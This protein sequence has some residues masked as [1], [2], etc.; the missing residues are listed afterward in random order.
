MIVPSKLGPGN[1]VCNWLFMFLRG[2]SHTERIG[3]TY[4]STL[5]LRTGLLSQ[6]HIV[7]ICLHMTV[8]PNMTTASKLIE[9]TTVT[10]LISASDVR[11]YRREVEDAT[12]RCN[13]NNLHKH[14]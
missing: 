13:D 1:S 14:Q 10:G 8:S 2:R 7:H 9:D 3:K 12:T 11:A 5:V 6:S 4:S